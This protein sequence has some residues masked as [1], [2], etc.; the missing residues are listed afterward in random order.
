[1][2]RFSSFC[3]TLACTTPAVAVHSHLIIAQ[4]WLSCLDSR[5]RKVPRPPQKASQ[6]LILVNRMKAFTATLTFFSCAL[7]FFG[8][9]ANCLHWSCNSIERKMTKLLSMVTWDGSRRC[10][11]VAAL[12]ENGRVV[13]PQDD[14]GWR[15]SK[16]KKIV[17]TRSTCLCTLLGCRNESWGPL[18]TFT[19]IEVCSETPCLK[20]PVA[21]HGLNSYVLLFYLIPE[22]K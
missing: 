12:C 9:L 18:S 6:N 13:D 20:H 15:Q 10:C 22:N 19:A 17:M 14:V 21:A 7:S 8:M 11:Q 16:Y 5:W 3:P 1:M 2:L 4:N